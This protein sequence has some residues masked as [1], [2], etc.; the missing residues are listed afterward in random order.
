MRW[1][2]VKYLLQQV[3][4]IKQ[5]WNLIVKLVVTT[6]VRLPGVLADVH[7]VDNLV[8]KAPH[9]NL[10][11]VIS[12]PPLWLVS[13]SSRSLIGQ[14]CAENVSWYL[15]WTLAQIC[16]IVCTIHFT[17]VS[18]GKESSNVNENDLRFF[19][20]DSRFCLALINKIKLCCH[21]MS[22]YPI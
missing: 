18:I 14:K 12:L 10:L 8:S 11:V 20:G 7:S 1:V 9:N 6:V 3:L 17:H 15:H 2:T 21:R 5:R 16:F 19:S 22:R 13:S 4:T